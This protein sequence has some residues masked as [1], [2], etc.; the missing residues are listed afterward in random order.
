MPLGNVIPYRI[1]RFL[2]GRQTW[3]ASLSVLLA[4]L[5]VV[6][7]FETW[8]E[9]DVAVL[10]GL[11]LVLAA[12]AG[13]RR[14]IWALVAV[15]LLVTFFVYSLQI[16]AGAF[17]IRE[18]F[19]VNRVLDAT[20]VLL[21][22]L[23]LHALTL[24][25]EQIKRQSDQ[26]ARQNAELERRRREAEL[27]S[28]RKTR[29]LASLSHDLGTPLTSIHVIAQ[30]IRGGAQR[31]NGEVTDL[32]HIL[33]AS[34]RSLSELVS[35]LLEL[36][37][38]DSGRLELRP[39][40]FSLSELLTEECR[41]LRPLASGKGLRLDVEP[42]PEIRVRADRVKLARI[43]RNL[44]TNAIKYTAAGRV[45]VNCALANGKV[46]IRVEDTGIGIAAQDVERI[47][48]EFAQLANG[49]TEENRGWGLGLAI[50]RRLVEL[51]G[52]TIAVQ[53]EPGR[54]SI[55]TVRLPADI[56]G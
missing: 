47:F 31:E 8:I 17:S 19:F 3:F 53:S 44:L 40:R 45:S 6:V 33:E 27:A 1:P 7:D 10:F 5:L 14:L 34:A 4:A 23:L 55:F 54:G 15:L 36:S 21:L 9:L 49:Q 22:A 2:A 42:M 12:M 46:L 26:I 39:T 32:A 20:A 28:E 41:S 48:A 38:I 24:A 50:A 30:L 13:K 18:P 56:V 35:D 52:G 51:M 43:A 16:P 29:L 11:P 25:I 37:S